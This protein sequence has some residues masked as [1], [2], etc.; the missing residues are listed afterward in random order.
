[1]G[2]IV[3]RSG[4]TGHRIERPGA[5]LAEGAHGKPADI[6]DRYVVAFLLAFAEYGDRL[7]FGGL[8][9]ESVRSVAGM[10]IA[11]AVDEGR[12][13]DGEWAAILGAKHQLARRMHHSMHR[14]WGNG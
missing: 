7:A 2:D 9:P 11:G 14:R 3:E 5:A 10:R 1:M 4:D 12:A 8:P 13:Q 6:L